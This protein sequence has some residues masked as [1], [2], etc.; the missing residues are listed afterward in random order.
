M[1]GDLP[2]PHGESGLSLADRHQPGGLSGRALPDRLARR[3]AVARLQ[4]QGRR[5]HRG[6][7]LPSSDAR[8]RDSATPFDGAAHLPALRARASDQRAVLPRMRDAAG[9]RR[10]QGGGADHRR[11]GAARARCGRST[12]GASLMRV[13]GA[14]NLADGEM[15]SGMLL[16]E[17]IP[18]WGAKRAA[19]TC[20]TSSPRDP[21][22]CSR[23]VGLEAA[24]E[25]AGA[26]GRGGMSSARRRGGT[27]VDGSPA[28]L[29]A[30]LLITLVLA[31]LVRV[32]IS[33][34]SPRLDA[35]R[36]VVGS[37]GSETRAACQASEVQS[38]GCS[39]AV[40]ERRARQATRPFAGGSAPDGRTPGALDVAHPRVEG[41]LEVGPRARRGGGVS[42]RTAAAS[43]PAWRASRS[44]T[45]AAQEEG[46][47]ARRR[48]EGGGRP[49]AAAR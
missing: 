25:R 12:R 30:G 47:R 24:R 31:A 21:A 20:R 46:V 35:T 33:S 8:V 26:A 4:H 41:K 29:A 44:K 49:R 48:E 23:G 40:A 37:G 45:G 15:I 36:R 34:I 16:E 11:A 28:R 18:A 9:L 42:A 22:M 1:V 38:R 10:G 19:S 6:R 32:P 43:G 13:G 14:R 17:G 2:L 7:P 27:A 39:G 5:G 3:G